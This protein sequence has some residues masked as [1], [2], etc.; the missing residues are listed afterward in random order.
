MSNTIREAAKETLRVVAGT[1]RT[2]IC[3]RESWWLTEE[4]QNKVK[5][6]QTRFRA[7]ISMQGD[8]AN[9][10]A[11]EERYKEVKR[12]AKKA[13]ARAKVKA[14]KDLYKR[15]DSKEHDPK[16]SFSKKSPSWDYRQQNEGRTIEMFVHVKRR[17]QSVHVRRVKSITV[18]GVRRRGRP[19][20]RW[21]DKLKIDLKELLF[22]KD[23][24][25]DRNS[26]RTR[27]R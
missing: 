13:V 5:A 16:W 6:K 19:K 27:I 7:L 4:V 23:M 20:L 12:E 24:T 26:W 8:E 14:Y 9:R 25:F 18:D 1:S 15:L 11:T 10:S 2:H 21:E 3:R 22:S 17:P